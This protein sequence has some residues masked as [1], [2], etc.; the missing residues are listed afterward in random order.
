MTGPTLLGKVT[1]AAPWALLGKLIRFGA[2][3][4]TSVVIVRALGAHD[5][6]LLALIRVSLAFLAL[7]AGVGMG[8]AL[9]RFLPELAIVG[10]GR[11]GRR[12][13][14]AGLVIQTAAWGLL[15]L[16]VYFA[17]AP[18]DRFFKADVASDLLLATLLLH[19]GTLRGFFESALT[20]SYEARFVAAMGTAGSVVLL[21]TT[22]LALSLGYGI[23]GILVAA[24]VGDLVPATGAMARAFATFRGRA[25]AIAPRRLLG[26]ALPFVLL[27]VLNMITWKQSE[28]LLLGHF[29]SPREAGLFDLAYKL[30]QQLLEFIPEAIWP[31]LLAAMSE[32]Y[33]KNPDTLRRVIDLY[34]RILFLVVPPLSVY[35]IVFGDRILTVL[36]GPEWAPAGIYCQLLF[37][38]FSLSFFGTP[39]S[40]AIY[41]LEKS[42]ANFLLAFL[43]AAINLGL[44]LLLIPRYGLAGALI[45]VAVAIGVSP[46]ARWFALRHFVGRVAIPWGF[47]G[48]SYRASLAILLLLPLKPFVRDLAS[49]A[50]ASGA[51]ALLVL[52][53]IRLF[54]VLSPMERDL[55]ARSQLPMKG[56]LLRVFAGS[57]A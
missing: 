22:W 42:W 38:V 26:Y 5:Y 15:A 13:L 47:I 45:P 16:G 4:L 12:L 18:I 41:V 56:A 21:A 29:F 32:A 10:G 24:A 6:G 23:P 19:V 2:G 34:Y 55:I 25:E 31:L 44:D 37:G 33:T 50:L 3:V 40:T 1:G 54:G 36:Y 7:P 35:G 9:L 49:L 27:S 48:R 30:P 51:A 52:A 11:G 39:L 43:F 46:V 57:P 17:R 14:V 8:Q 53:A 28:T 20:A